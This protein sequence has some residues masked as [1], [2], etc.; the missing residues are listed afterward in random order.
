M[1]TE[2]FELHR[3][4]EQVKELIRFIDSDMLNKTYG[5]Y[6]IGESIRYELV[7]MGMY[8]IDRLKHFNVFKKG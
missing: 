7:D 8:L 6:L 2:E 5:T 1:T 4:L 3:K